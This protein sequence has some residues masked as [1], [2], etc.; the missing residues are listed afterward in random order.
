MHAN[1]DIFGVINERELLTANGLA[2][3][4]GVNLSAVR[5]G[6]IF[7]EFSDPFV[8]ERVVRLNE[9]YSRP[10]E[11]SDNRITIISRTFFEGRAMFLGHYLESGTRFLRGME[12]DYGVL[13]M[14]KFNTAQESY[15]SF[16]NAWNCV[17]VGVPMNS[18]NTET[19][20]FI[21]EAL[22]YASYNMVR[23]AV[24]NVVLEH[25]IARDAESARVIDIILES[26]YLDF[27][28]IYNWGGA[29][30]ALRHAIFD[31]TP[32]VSAIDARTSQIQ[33]AI[34]N[35]ISAMTR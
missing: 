5:D 7:V 20:G 12:I 9:I 27:N 19:T 35:F 22:A 28:G 14:P 2:A 17:F 26:S 16:L 21:M 29:N 3:S 34:D 32:L 23:P 33:S 24:H 31:G 6:E 4:V 11:W 15:V 1:H 8:L 18:Q 25:R 30:D 10:Y 13:P